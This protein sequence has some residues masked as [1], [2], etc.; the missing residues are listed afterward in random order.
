[1][2]TVQ[3]V[4]ILGVLAAWAVLFY[5]ILRWGP[6]LA[7]RSVRCPQK[8]VRAKL[9]VEQREDE[10]GSLRVVDVRKCSLFPDSPITCNKE[11]LSRL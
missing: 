4:A 10:F 1:M 9:V 8:D 2:E 6:G 11:C 7:G 3:I 5:T